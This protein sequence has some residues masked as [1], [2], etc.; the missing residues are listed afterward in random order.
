MSHRSTRFVLPVLAA[1][2]ALSAAAQD[3]VAQAGGAP[4]QPAANRGAPT[5]DRRADEQ[6]IRALSQRWL[7]AQRKKDVDGV[8]AQFAPGAVAIYDGKQLTGADAIRRRY[9]D[10]FARNAKERPDYAPS[11]QTTAVEVAQAGDLAWESGTY[12]DRW[13]AGKGR[14]RGHYLTVW[15]KTGGQWKVARD[16]AAPEA[17]PTPARKPA[18]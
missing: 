8:M 13:N 16:I 9:V 6:A 1:L 18:P 3:G 11:W 7:A 4:A 10:D 5:G 14:D 17:A 15:R 12:D 2:A